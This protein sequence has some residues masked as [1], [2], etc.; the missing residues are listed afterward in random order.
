M[1]R[2]W[3]DAL[4]WEPYDEFDRLQEDEAKQIEQL[5]TILEQYKQT[6]SLEETKRAELEEHRSEAKLIRDKATS[7]IEHTAEQGCV[8]AIDPIDPELERLNAHRIEQKK[9]LEAIQARGAR[10]TSLR[11]QVEQS[12]AQI[13]DSIERDISCADSR[14]VKGKKAVETVAGAIASIP[15]LASNIEQEVSTLKTYAEELKKCIACDCFEAYAGAHL[16]LTMTRSR[17]R[18][19][20]KDVARWL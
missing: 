1:Q 4:A 10:L 2:Q 3:K 17:K 14:I 8:D 19:R 15:T 9:L 11:A 5:S 6:T 12:Y 7:M 16:V 13:H 20:W 18:L